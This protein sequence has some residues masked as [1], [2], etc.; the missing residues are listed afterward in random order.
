MWCQKNYAIYQNKNW[1]FQENKEVVP[2]QATH[3]NI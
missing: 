3:I 1:T 2:A